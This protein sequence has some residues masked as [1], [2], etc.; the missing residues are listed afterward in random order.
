MPCYTTGSAE[1]DAHLAAQEAHEAAT[2]ASR[3]AC[4]ALNLIEQRGAL[5]FVSA[6]TLTWWREHQKTDRERLRREAM[7]KLT[8]AERRALGVANE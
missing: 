6:D 1:G 4:D 8:P 7:A 2:K 5:S 3:A